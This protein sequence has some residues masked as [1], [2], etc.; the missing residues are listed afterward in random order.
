M[1][2][3]I[4]GTAGHVDHGKTVLVEALTGVNTDRWEE[5]RERGITIDLGFA[6]LPSGTDELEVSVIDVPGH[7][8]FVKNMLAGATGVD[9]LLLVVAAD[10][11]PMPQTREHLW[12]ARLLGVETGVVA[13]TKTDLV[14][15]DFLGLVAE[16]VRDELARIF[17][18]SDW[19]IVPVSARA[20]DGIDELKAVVLDAAGRARARH[21][22]DLFRMPVDRSFSVRGVGTVVTGTVWSGAVEAGEEVRILPGERAT[23]VR[24]VQVHSVAVHQAAAGQRAALALVGIELSEVG[25]G[26]VLVESSVWR[27]TR[28][29]DAE[30]LLL[31]DSPWPLKYW[32]RVRFHIGTAETMARVVLFD[33]NRLEPGDR[34]LVQFRLEQPVV[35]RAGDRYVVRFYSPVTTVGGGVV[36]HPWAPRHA[37]IGEAAIERLRSVAESD[38]KDRLARVMGELREGA[39]EAE[40]AILVGTTPSELSRD[41]AE[42]ASERS[43]REIGGRWYE[44]T[45]I[46]DVRR[47]LT[48]EISLSHAR[49]ADAP[50]VSLES[51]RSAVGAPPE[52]VNAVLSDLQQDGAIRIEGSVAALSGHVPKLS[53]VQEAVGEVALARIREAGLAP[54]AV[55]ELAAEAGVPAD[56][57]LAVLKFLCGQG[58]LVAVTPDLYYASGAIKEVKQSVKATLG[59]GQAATPAELRG[60]LGISRKYLIPLLEYLDAEGFTRRSG[61]G[62]VLREEP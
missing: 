13:I 50:G 60:A 22:D 27:E 9:V 43:L 25:R 8:D 14:D 40:L 39:S 61:E 29:L 46:S 12:I 31:A 32:Q 48:A 52:L 53:A 23:R 2:S 18:A 6:P 16:S 28:Y 10:E 37:R 5:E 62:R 55:K 59:R 33:R 11:G 54:P 24:G 38:G 26:D 21:D 34:A 45:A 49:K 20:G 7:E 1:K 35:A 42:L 56:R 44:A 57:L 4:V 15:E 36:V 47:A 58:E 19:P 30:L 3:V 41:L 17:P 51:L